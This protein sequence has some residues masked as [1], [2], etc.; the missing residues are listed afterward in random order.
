MVASFTALQLFSAY[1]FGRSSKNSHLTISYNISLYCDTEAA[2]YQN[3]QIMYCY[4]STSYIL[5]MCD[6]H[7]MNIYHDINDGNMI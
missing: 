3:T 2:I 6:I 5:V 4:T 1:N 7:D